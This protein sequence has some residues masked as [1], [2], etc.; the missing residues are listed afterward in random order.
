[1][2]SVSEMV[3]SDEFHKRRSMQNINATS[4][5]L[6]RLLRVTFRVPLRKINPIITRRK[7]TLISVF[8]TDFT[9]RFYIWIDFPVRYAGLSRSSR[10][11]THLIVHQEGR[12]RYKLLYKAHKAHKH[13]PKSCYEATEKN[14]THFWELCIRPTS[15]WHTY[16]WHT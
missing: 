13:T 15:N 5:E 3:T 1:M 9:Y 12:Q 14:V 16:L 8:K 10:W 4:L 6:S 7:S 2:F 11:I